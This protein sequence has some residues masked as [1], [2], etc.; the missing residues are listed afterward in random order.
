M[1]AK[2]VHNMINPPSI[3]KNTV[4]ISAVS[5]ATSSLAMAAESTATQKP[6][7]TDTEV[8]T[9]KGR[10]AQ[11]YFVEESMMA[12]KTPTSYM[13]LPQS[14]QVLSTELIRDQAARQTSDLY[15]SISGI[16]QFSYSGVTARGFRQ[17]QVRYDG[18]Q[19]DPY[20]GFSIPQLF[21]IEQVAVLKGPTGMLYGSGQPGGLLNYISKKPKFSQ[22]TELAF[23]GGSDSLRGA[24]AQT[25]GPMNKDSNLAY[26]LAGFSQNKKGFRNNTDEKN[27]LLS[28]GLTWLASDAVDLTLQYDYIDQDLAGHRLRGVPVDD[29]GNFLT[30]ISYNANEKSDFQRLS[31]DVWQLIANSEISDN[32]TNRTVLRRLDNERTQQYHE[33]RGL[34]DDGVSMVRE[35]RDQFRTN[36]ELS[37]TTDFVYQL[38]TGGI[39]HQLLFGGDY[40][41]S[42]MFYA[43]KLGRGAP[44]LIPDLNIINPVYE[45]NSANYLLLQRPDSV[46]ES[47]RTGLY[48]QDQ[49]RLN[50]RWL[51]VVGGRYD[52]FEDSTFSG[53]SASDQFNLSDS[54]FSPRIGAIYQPDES[55]SVFAN[56]TQG[57]APQSLYNQIQDSDD[58]DTIGKLNPETSTQHEIG[59]KNQWLNNSLLTTFTAYN[60]VKSDVVVA[61]PADTG[62]NDG[63]AAMLQVGEVTSKGIEIDVIGDLGEHWTGTINY[64]YNQAKITGGAPDAL[65]NTVGD[66]F[67][68]APDHTL[69]I[70]TRWAIPS[71]D[72]SFAIGAD[73]VSERISLSGQK[74][75][76]YTVWDASW[77][78]TI[79]Q[80]ELQLNLKNLF[81]K[82]YATSGFNQRNG[83]FPGEPR[84]ILVQLSYAL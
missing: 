46:S 32:L 48:V 10:A 52:K 30:D 70:W 37:L 68:N 11:F 31:A 81:D 56:Y 80:F 16:T 60:I 67:V 23:I 66:E 21:N 29:N 36:E 63:I 72:S 84:S 45:N 74:V 47:R 71:L 57:F 17:D 69:G 49:F 2:R 13:D 8:I 24:Y 33:N 6:A 3:L 79:N 22:Q 76:P 25:T 40:F 44:S 18:V 12:T 50:E 35:F 59:I 7:S 61:N 41:T 82:R 20:S 73:Y 54:S 34:A 77:Q 1:K 27:T 14:L 38:T 26:R 19:G 78:T 51:G 65:R 28:G 58:S 62:V 43:A 64:A 5:I 53:S 9:V 4:F 39:E 83:H 55:M 15:R 75:K 42:D